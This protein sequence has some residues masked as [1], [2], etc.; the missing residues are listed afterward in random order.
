MHHS[1]PLAALTLALAPAPVVA[2]AAYEPPPFL[3]IENVQVGLDPDL[4]RSTLVLRDGRIEAVLAAGETVPAGAFAIDATGLIALPAFIDAYTTVGVETPEPRIDRDQPLDVGSDVRIDM[5][6]A[7]RKGLAP[8]FDA[9]DVASLEEE[10]LGLYRKSGFGLA[11][12]A[13]SGQLL[14]GN[15]VLVSLR[16]AA[17][18][19]RVVRERAFAHSAFRASGDG[20][21]STLM[22]YFAQLRQFFLDARRHGEL[23]ERH[24]LGRPGPRPPFDP[25]LDAGHDLLAGRRVVMAEARTRK[26]VERFLS[27]ASEFGLRIGVSGGRD[28]H[29]LADRLRTTR[30]PLVLTLDP[31]EEPKDPR[32]K[33]P[34]SGDQADDEGSEESAAGESAAEEPEGEDD[35]DAADDADRWVYREPYSVRLERRVEWERRRDGALRLTEAGVPYGLGTGDG[36]PAKLLERL[37]G[38]VERGLAEEKALAALTG[39]PA[40]MFGL[41]DRL[42]RVGAGTDA[43]LAL[44]TANPLTDEQARVAW[45]FVDGHAWENPDGAGD[46][47]D[48]EEDQ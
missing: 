40:R 24:E 39:V 21:P 46:T 11:V 4:G 3:A 8:S 48:S 17:L 33:P 12:Q 6:L 7:N 20:Y 10:R 25:D 37:R 34:A 43:T 15:S 9:V 16:D 2:Q 28:A 19:D 27:F 22:G 35:A 38:L 30:L 26:D 42:G 32:P 18:R 1:P 45:M 29:E 31:G 41:E 5:R 14:S 13:P 44:W 36:A 47:Q 23:Q